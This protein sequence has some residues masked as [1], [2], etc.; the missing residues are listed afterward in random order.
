MADVIELTR[1][2]LDFIN[3]VANGRTAGASRGTERSAY[4]KIRAEV[5]RRLILGLPFKTSDDKSGP[6]RLPNGLHAKRFEVDNCLD[7]S[8][9]GQSSDIASTAIVFDDVIIPEF[10][11]K[12]ANFSRIAITNS[13]IAKINIESVHLRGDLDLS[14]LKPVCENGECTVHAVR[15]NIG[16][17]IYLNGAT[18][19]AK[20]QDDQS[21]S[22]SPIALDL[23]ESTIGGSLNLRD[24]FKSTGEI[25]LGGAT[26]GQNIKAEGAQFHATGDHAF[27]ASSAHILGSIFLCSASGSIQSS[28]F[29]ARGTIYLAYARI[30]KAL[31]MAGAK[32]D[33][34]GNHAIVAFNAM[35]GGVVDLSA[36]PIEEGGIVRFEASG[37]LVFSKAQIGGDLQ[38][39]G[40]HLDGHGK[41]ALNA[42]WLKM[43]GSLYAGVV[44]SGDKQI[45]RFESEGTI[46]LGLAQIGGN[47]EFYGASIDGKGD[48]SVSAEN[49]EVKGNFI[50]R[51]GAKDSTSILRFQTKGCF[52][53]L[54]AKIHGAMEFTGAKLDGNG[55]DALFAAYMEVGSFLNVCASEINP[56]TISIFEAIGC[57]NLQAATIKGYINFS[58]ASL[59]GGEQAALR[60][61]TISVGGGVHFDMVEAKGQSIKGF[62]A[63]GSIFARNARIAGDLDLTGAQLNG[64]SFSAL[65]L[66]ST[67][68]GGSISAMPGIDIDGN[69]IPFQTTGTVKLRHATIVGAIDFAGACLSGNGN[70]SIS[71][72]NMSVTG[73]AS[74]SSAIDDNDQYLPFE[75]KGTVDLSMASIGDQLSFIGAQLDGNGSDSILAQRIEVGESL[76]MRA[77]EDHDTNRFQAIGT[78][79]LLGAKIRGRLDLSGAKLDGR[80]SLALGMWNAEIGEDIFLRISANEFNNHH[81]FEAEGTVD[82]SGSKINGDFL[83]MGAR[84]NGVD[85]SCLVLNDIEIEGSLFLNSGYIPKVCVFKLKTNGLVSVKRGKIGGNVELHGASLNGNGQEALSLH[86]TKVG[87]AVVALPIEDQTGTSV[88]PFTAVGS[89]D[90]RNSVIHGDLKMDGCRL[91]NSDAYALLADS[92]QVDQDFSLSISFSTTNKAYRSM[93]TGGLSLDNAKIGGNLD[94]IG[95]RIEF[96]ERLAVSADAIEVAGHVWCGNGNT[97]QGKPIQFE[98]KGTLHLAAAKVGKSMQLNGAKLSAP[99]RG[100]CINMQRAHIGESLIMRTVW[101]RD[102]TIA[103]FEAEGEIFL[104]GAT[105][106]GVLELSGAKLSNPTGFAMMA[107]NVSVGEDVKLIPWKTEHGHA[108]LL[109]NANI[110]L[111]GSSIK[112]TLYIKGIGSEAFI[113]EEGY[114]NPDA[115]TLR[116][117]LMT[118]LIAG[119]IKKPD[120]NSRQ[121]IKLYLQ[122]VQA[123]NF[124]T[125]SGAD[126]GREVRVE[127]NGFRFSTLERASVQDIKQKLSISQ[128]IGIWLQGIR[129]P[130]SIEMRKFWLNLQYDNL[131]PTKDE[132]NPYPY[133]QI[134]KVL[135]DAGQK[136][137]AKKIL[138]AKLKARS[139]T[140]W[141]PTR[142]FWSIYGLL[143]G[144]GLSGKRAIA[145][146]I[147]FVLIGVA[148]TN[149]LKERDLLVLETIH[150]TTLSHNGQPVT[151]AD[152]SQ[153]NLIELPCGSEV[154]PWIYALDLALPIVQLNEEQRC[155]V[156][157]ATR[158]DPIIFSVPRLV[159]LGQSGSETNFAI[160]SPDLWRAVKAVY[161]FI[162]W[163]VTSIMLLTMTGVFRRIAEK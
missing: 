34:C 63:V 156:R 101:S 122:D 88:H 112:G 126:F 20:S 23:N 104:L 129:F 22:E 158:S 77:D 133:E 98:T 136:D 16:G 145:T 100:K 26:I 65:D 81:P 50:C 117:R 154:S 152:R 19:F 29:R 134:A 67:H 87:G 59:N 155:K 74:F 78:I 144:Y 64:Q 106:G 163:I 80:G 11:A 51:S 13:R 21:E 60:A 119:K 14:F 124:A 58:G 135:D 131:K 17:G 53:L 37:S 28:R 79:K 96:P 125:N 99:S 162:G 140:L 39:N 115:M 72:G 18:L 15:A 109:S 141:W 149:Y 116:Q 49:L 114:L 75:T 139:K 27:N 52:R 130:H 54:N 38:L 103:R 147:L 1:A 6:V 159:F 90:L 86:G 92:L 128:K 31:I 94:L 24:G 108:Q 120:V 93:L 118:R 41:A 121:R 161:A 107:N 76:L 35:I 55:E 127:L 36:E 105:V 56:G 61:N 132:Y 43:K 7:I 33:G 68:I 137:A 95:T 110:S 40:A 48:L 151:I 150:V 69:L 89:I 111:K 84:F 8:D 57:L 85:A 157:A 83:C 3:T 32:L 30:D 148:G 142:L 47:V 97:S 153:R 82:M 25:Y 71:A 91:E 46:A 70:E 5:I 160:R 10:V 62:T 2:E 146:F 42:S 138:I 66:T 4:P 45:E 12:H 73:G 123:T 44:A 9:A 113:L 143:F 102:G